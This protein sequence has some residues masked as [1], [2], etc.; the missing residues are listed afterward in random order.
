MKVIMENWRHSVLLEQQLIE[1]H[2]QLVN[3]FVLELKQIQESTD[4]LNEVLAK[5]ADFLL[6][7]HLTHIKILKI[8]RSKQY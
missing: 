1:L 2:E 4:D 3:E 6:K 5:V 7:G 8:I